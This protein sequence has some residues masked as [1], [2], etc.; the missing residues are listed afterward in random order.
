MR[1]AVTDVLPLQLLIIL[2]FSSPTAS[3]LQMTPLSLTPRLPTTVF[4]GDAPA[5]RYGDPAYRPLSDQARRRRGPSSITRAACRKVMCAAGQRSTPLGRLAEQP[6]SPRR[7]RCARCPASMRK[8]KRVRSLVISVLSVPIL[9]RL[10]LHMGEYGRTI[11]LDMLIEPD[12]RG[13]IRVTATTAVPASIPAAAGRLPPSHRCP[14][15]TR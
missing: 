8:V 3:C 11:A 7:Q 10:P 2:P 15:G 9:P 5:A 13:R 14:P 12:A 6:D 1:A 4:G